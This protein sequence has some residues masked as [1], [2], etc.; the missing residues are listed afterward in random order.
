M[1]KRIATWLQLRVHGVEIAN[2]H[3]NCRPRGAV[4]VVRG[5]VKPQPVARDL[6]IDR[7]VAFPILRRMGTTELICSS[8]ATGPSS[9]IG[10]A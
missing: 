5:E 8:I 2:H 10:R 7:A 6:Q 1:E 3:Q 9:D 4:I